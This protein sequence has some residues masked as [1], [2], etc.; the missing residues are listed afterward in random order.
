VTDTAK[1]LYLIDG[2]GFIF[3]A[4]HALPPL[5]RPDGT[6][7][8]AVMGFCNIILRVLEEAGDAHIGVVFD[9]SGPNFRHDIY[10]QYK[11]NRSEPPEDLK[12]QFALVK[13]AT[14]A[15]GLVRIE[16]KGFEAD[17]LIATYTREA[18]VR[19]YEVRIISADKDLMQLVRDGVRLVDPIKFGIIGPD[20]VFAKFGVT[21]DKVVDIQ[22][23]A[24]DSSDNVPGVPSIG[25][26]TAAE[27]INTYG[28][29]ENL[30]ANVENIKQPKRREVLTQHAEMARISKRLVQLDENVELPLAFDDLCPHTP[31]ADKLTPFL[32]EQGFRSLTARVEKKWAMLG[33]AET[34]ADDF[35][36]EPPVTHEM[37]E[38][39]YEL[40]TTEAQLDAWIA[41]GFEKGIIA[42]DTETN[43]LTPA[44][45]DLVG[46]SLATA[47]GYACYIPV[48]HVKSAN[49]FSEDNDADYTQLNKALVM[50]K[51]KPLLEDPSV[52][53]VAQNLKYDWQMFAKEDIRIA[54]IDDTMVM[55][56]CLDGSL[57]GHGLDEL[58]QLHFGETLISYDSLTGK[59]KARKTLDE[60]SP[61]DVKEYASEDADMVL[62]LYHRLQP[63]LV[64][65]KRMALYQEIDKPIVTLLAEMELRGITVD[66]SMLQKMSA[67]FLEKMQSAEHK[68]YAH[69]GQEFNLASPKQ[70]GDILF[71][72]L[73]LPGGKKTKMG[74]YSTD[75]KTLEDLSIK[76]HDIADEIIQWRQLAKL[77]ST[78]TESLQE[79]ISPRDGRVHTSF[80]LTVTN[81]GRLSST[82]PN[83]QNIPIR[84]EEGRL[85]R[86]AFVPAP[87]HKLISVDYSQIELR[88]VAEMA[89]LKR[90]QE[91]FR[92]NVDIHAM[93]A[94]EVFGI[95]LEEVS[96]ERRRAAKAIN[97]GIIYGISGF[98]LAKQLN[99]DNSTASAYIKL[100]MQ[101]FPELAAYMEN[102][103][104]FA[105][106]NG[107]VETLLGRKIHMPGINSKNG[108]ERA[109]AER[110]AINAPIQG[111]AADIMKLA[112]T[113]V[114][115]II[116]EKNLPARI[117]LQV[118][119]ELV[120]EVEENAVDT[121]GIAVKHAMEHAYEMN[122]PLIAEWGSGNNWDEAH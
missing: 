66:R 7:V 14:D 122:T 95:P 80:T 118:H 120:I 117:L 119:D 85:I 68:I 59:G 49:L 21:P 25:I 106:A 23:L 19:G 22:A 81:T 44:N 50:Q 94:S 10:D 109:F 52:L 116:H 6:P 75:A 34:V 60:L 74:A 58:S 107:Y 103:K 30:L 20:E 15:F 105:K 41:R 47:P 61:A 4:F 36:V 3:R 86:T 110:Q 40:V 79:Q 88:L 114:N 98:G 27:L 87:G 35:P 18:L 112:M 96:S 100:Y 104:A 102:T 84:T 73:G 78:Y 115:R 9:P 26:K 89:Q 101:R 65:E 71:N 1:T 93:T 111:T 5:T 42:F 54:P 108:A 97:F 99:T 62:R 70:L 13:E 72:T 91:A 45:A 77:R 16:K 64:Q 82:D 57:H 39:H 51:L 37:I 113:A 90:L 29:L 17:D 2:H 32:R 31:D 11:A 76:G 48:G 12:P 92:N 63:R 43:S 46:I 28:D 67:V 55:S 38:R 24:G 8:G 121:V 69:V 53:K 83:L 33:T 56:Y